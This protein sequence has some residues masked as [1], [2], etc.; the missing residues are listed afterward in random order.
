MFVRCV[1]AHKGMIDNDSVYQ[2]VRTLHGRQ[3]VEIGGLTVYRLKVRHVVF[4]DDDGVAP[5]GTNGV[6]HRRTDAVLRLCIAD[7]YL[8]VGGFRATETVDE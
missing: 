7:R 2:I 3:R 6:D 8:E 4:L 1:I 5:Y